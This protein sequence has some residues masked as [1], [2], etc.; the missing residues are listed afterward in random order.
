MREHGGDAAPAAA[1][2]RIGSV[3]SNIG[4]CESAAGIAGLTKI[5]LQLEHA[6]LVPTLHAQTLNPNIDFAQTPFA[7]QRTLEPWLAPSRADASPAPRIAA[8]SSFGAG[9]SNAHL[10]VEEF[11]A[12]A[13]A[14]AP[15]PPRPALIVLSA[16]ESERL[17]EAARRLLA[18]L[19]TQGFGD[20]D[21]DAIACTLQTGREHHA[22]RL[23]LSAGSIAELRGKL[24]GFL[25]GDR[26]RCH[27]GVA[28]P[29]RAQAPADDLLAL[30]ERGEQARVLAAW[31]AGV[32]WPW[33]RLYLQRPTRL[34][35]PTYPFARERYWAPD[36][37]R[38]R[39]QAATVAVADAVAA[40]A[41]AR[42]EIVATGQPQTVVAA[43]PAAAAAGAPAQLRQV[44]DVLRETLAEVL[45]MKP[46][47]VGAH[48]TFADLGMDSVMGV[49][50]LPMIQ[51]RLGV[52][53]GATKIYEHPTIRELAAYVAAQMP[54][55]APVAAAAPPQAR[56]AETGS[57][58]APA[59]VAAAITPASESSA[60]A[61]LREVEDV[62]RETLAEVLYM[63][64]GDVG[65]N[66]PFVDLGMDSVM[67]VEWLPMIQQRLGV[68]LGATKTYEYPTIRDLAGYVLAQMPAAVAPSS[69]PAG[70]PDPVDRW[71]QAIYEG[72]ADPAEAQQW[73]ATLETEETSG[74]TP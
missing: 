9:G 34:R 41:P 48:T 73:L 49:E 11:L 26:S 39:T 21:L 5:L 32:E 67:G 8:L 18:S 45:Y 66:T 58:S 50:W 30:L 15:R 10:L 16:A 55:A 56:V 3:K 37:L 68:S 61:Q 54:A 57:A 7:V 47:D 52:S 62:L 14:S 40:T 70:E 69:S 27:R 25:A 71:L 1:S 74:R 29:E 31:V 72:R 64:P 20:A 2:I 59:A 38:P 6:T 22:H 12:P 19:S 36:A 51:Q 60:P 65:V 43:V 35:L 28:D 4:H 42:G 13:R 23:G 17:D 46:A 63:K 53:L 24:E 44:E 33:T